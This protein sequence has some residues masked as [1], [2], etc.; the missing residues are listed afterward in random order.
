M[1]THKIGTIPDRWDIEHLAGE[2]FEVAVPVLD[3][4]GAAVLAADLTRARVHVRGAVDSDQILTVFDTAADP[5][6][7]V[8]SGGA[9]A[10]VTISATSAETSDW[11]VIWPGANGASV[12]WWDVEVVDTTDEPHQLMRPGTITLIHEVTR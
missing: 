9:A 3:G 11:A 4:T 2:P 10:V 12:V 7:A 8:I 6:N 1:A 5:P